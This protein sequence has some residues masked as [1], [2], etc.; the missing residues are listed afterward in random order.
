[1]R[2]ILIMPVI[3]LL[4]SKEVCAQNDFRT[5]DR[6]T[7]DYF[8][9]GDYKNLKQTA[10]TLHLLGIDYYYLR[11]R[12]GLTGYY[13]QDYPNAV[14]DLSRA[15]EFNPL[16]T[17][18]REY[19]YNSYIFSGRKAD[20]ILYLN[21]IP[22]DERNASLRAQYLTYPAEFFMGTSGTLYDVFNYQSNSLDYEAIKSNLSVYAGVESYFLKRFKGTLTYTNFHKSGTQ[23][24]PVNTS[25]KDLNFIQNQLYGKI[26]ASFFPGWEVS[27]FSHVAYYNESVTKGFPGNRFSVNQITTEYLLG[28]GGT[29]NLWK[30]RAGANVS[31]SNFGYSTQIRGEGYF[32]WLPAGN[33][34][35]YLTSGWMGQSDNN[36]GGTYQVSGE[37]GLKIFKSL[38]LESG[39]VKGNS[40]LYARNLGSMINNSFQ[41]PATT[42]YSNLIIL[43]GKRF[44]LT[45]T[46]FYSENNIYSWDL[47]AYSRTNKL[48]IN[49]FGGLVKLTYK[50]R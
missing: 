45:I 9:K 3:L 23:Y 50:Y 31:L 1:M 12:L 17:I 24:S 18:S 30:I 8:I 44:N 34:N 38:W 32:T 21:S 4:L 27:G 43:P 7:Y 46:P 5:L 40:F 35:L 22:E 25:G 15:I 11:E 39:L 36:W 42:I 47:F 29:K 19:I 14:R 2:I 16:D 33:L 41:I 37:I 49:S 20:A 28:I 48:I 6:K 10:D 26:S 13:K